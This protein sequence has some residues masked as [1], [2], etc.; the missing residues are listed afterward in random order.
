[1]AD[2]LEIKYRPQT[3][4]PRATMRLKKPWN[5]YRRG[6]ILEVTGEDNIRELLR[7]EAEVVDE[8]KKVVAEIPI[9]EKEIEKIIKKL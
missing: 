3:W 9:Q 4:I 5:G 6:T 1:M 7:L 8:K 2:A